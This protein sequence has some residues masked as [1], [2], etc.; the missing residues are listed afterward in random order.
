MILANS[1]MTHVECISIYRY[2]FMYV[3]SLVFLMYEVATLF[4]SLR[5]GGLGFFL[6]EHAAQF[7]TNSECLDNA[8]ASRIV[9]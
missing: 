3:Q 6:A 5:V 7:Y 9:P 1:R 4:V 2:F 8:Q